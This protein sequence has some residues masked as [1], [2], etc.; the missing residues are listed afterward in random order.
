MAVVDEKKKVIEY[1]QG[2]LFGGGSEKVIQRPISIAQ[3]DDN[4]SEY[5]LGEIP[6]EAVI[7]GLA[8]MNT[9]I[10]GGTDFDLGFVDQNGNVIAGMADKLFDGIDMSSARAS[11]GSIAMNIG[12]ANMGKTVAE[13]CGHVSKVVPAVGEVAAKAIYRIILKANTVGSAD[14]TV[15]PQVRYRDSI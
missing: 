14:G 15:V 4:G 9:L 6:G 1:P 8:C 11:M 12:A 5:L 2:P 3:A 7:T 13:L 10:T